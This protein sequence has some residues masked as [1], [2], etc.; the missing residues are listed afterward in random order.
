ML[1]YTTLLITSFLLTL[2][3]LGL[4][5]LV[6]FVA[7]KVFGLGKRVAEADL[8]AYR[9]QKTS[10]GSLKA[11]PTYRAREFYATAPALAKTD[12][13]APTWGGSGNDRD[14]YEHSSMSATAGRGSLND[15]LASKYDK[16]QNVGDWKRN[17]G[18]PARDDTSALAGTAYRPSQDAISKFGINE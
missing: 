9:R 11:I 10:D 3:I 8:A 2:A 5:Y 15:Y 1:F 18:R 13:A 14:G 17:I 4:K 12:T 16:K 6:V 7:R